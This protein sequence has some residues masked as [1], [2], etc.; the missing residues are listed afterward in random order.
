VKPSDLILTL[1]LLFA[2]S[3]SQGADFISGADVSHLCFFE[4]RGV[5]YQEAGQPQDALEMLRR[6]CLT[7]V[8]LRLFTSSAEQAQADPY[9]CINNLAYT[10]PLA[11]RAK[12]A[13]LQ[14]MLDFH[15]SDTWADPGHQTKPAA[16]TNL[17]F[18][19][20]E[21]QMYEYNRNCLAAF[22]AAGAMPEFVEVG[23]EITSGL[24]WPDGRV[25]GSY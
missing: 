2:A 7:C 10:L 15:Y 21:E 23:N 9:D 24:L 1:L 16:W 11:V 3:G 19:L 13:G 4:E 12:K 17:A 8:R 20:L 25:G 22:K 18:P 14:L 5:I 6:H